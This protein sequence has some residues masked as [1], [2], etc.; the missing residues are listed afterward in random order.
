[1]PPPAADVA[2]EPAPALDEIQRL[3][4]ELEQERDRRLRTLADYDNYRKRTQAEFGRLFQSAGERIIKGLLPIMDDFERF[5]DH[6][7]D[8]PGSDAL[9]RGAELIHK[10]LGDL[11]RMEGLQPIVAANQPFD[12]QIHEAVSQVENHSLPDGVVLTEVERGYRLGDRIIRHPRVIVNQLPA[13][14]SADVVDSTAVDE[15]A[16]SHPNTDIQPN[17]EDPR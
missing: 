12:P 6:P 11:L 14:H 5:L 16:R 17:E 15:S 13:D 8:E 3:R 9:K 4:A 1:M 10:K 2:G 7:P